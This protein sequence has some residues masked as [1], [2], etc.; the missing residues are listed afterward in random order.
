M[1]PNF[2]IYV[3]A[4]DLYIPMIGLSILLQPN[5]QTNPGNIYCKWLTEHE[6]RNWERGRP[7]SFLGTHKSDSRYSAEPDDSTE[8]N[9]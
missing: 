5:R 4:G 2:H 3:S 1:S 8:A 7:V 6:C 9:T